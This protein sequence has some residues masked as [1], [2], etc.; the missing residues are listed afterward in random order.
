[1]K[2]RILLILLIFTLGFVA[3]CS[4]S[5]LNS[6]DP[7]AP[8]TC[9]DGSCPLRNPNKT[10]TIPVTHMEIVDAENISL[11]LPNPG[12]IKEPHPSDSFTI[13]EEN[14]EQQCKLIMVKEPTTEPYAQYVVGAIREFNWG[15]L[16]LHDYRQVVINNQSFVLSQD[17]APTKT[18]WV[19]FTSK[20][21]FG[22]WMMCMC[23][24][25]ADS[26]VA[27]RDMCQSI[28][29]SIEIK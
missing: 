5:A 16:R 12:W 2:K 26:G 18:A 22:Y 10:I 6:V 27:K 29:E 24:T 19:W 21:H 7:N 23:V 14:A 1:M 25:D 28:A 15:G 17:T 3:L 9:S 13:S 4:T 11:T 8:T 20:D